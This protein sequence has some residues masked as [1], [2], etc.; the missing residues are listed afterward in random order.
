MEGS[1]QSPSLSLEFSIREL[2]E[3]RL[4]HVVEVGLQVHKGR[5]Q[6]IQS[7]VGQGYRLCV[8][9]FR[10]GFEVEAEVALGVVTLGSCYVRLVRDGLA[11]PETDTGV[12]P[13]FGDVVV[14]LPLVLPPAEVAGT[15]R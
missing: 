2:A 3:I 1:T 5:W 10:K 15:L 13:A 14:D 11:R 8:L 7:V 4:V 9:H 6:R 12:M